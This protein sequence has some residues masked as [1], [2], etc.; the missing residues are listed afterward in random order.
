MEA[1]SEKFMQYALLAGVIGGALLS[2]LGV[3]IVLKRIAFVGIALSQIAALGIAL[4]LFLGINADVMSFV[5]TI[6]GILFFW[7]LFHE[8]R[9]SRESIIGF[10]YALATAL[11]I[12]I[13][14]KSPMIESSG[15]DL[16]SGNLLYVTNRD[17]L[18]IFVITILFIVPHILFAKKLIFISFDRETAQ[19]S[20][21]NVMIY[22][23]I[24]YLTI[25]LAIAILVRITGVLFVFA[26][27][28]VPPIIALTIFNRIQLIFAASLFFSVISVFIGLVI[29]YHLD[30][31]STPTIVSCYGAIFII[32]S[33]LVYLKA[34][35]SET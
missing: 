28:I 13:V 11:A 10:S 29:S 20:G 25:G 23:L 5:F 14:S 24:L 31:P 27:L 2:Y 12:L 34:K 4:G 33:A 21:F 7:M 32:A 8:E 9:M 22:D 18:I 30:L 35:I 17:L 19:A 16:I 1:F 3:Y 15:I 6:L 26:T